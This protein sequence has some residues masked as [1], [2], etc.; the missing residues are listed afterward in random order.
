[1]LA[2]FDLNLP[3]IHRSII[4]TENRASGRTKIRVIS[5]VMHVVF[6]AG[7]WTMYTKGNGSDWLEHQQ[8][9]VTQPAR[10]KKCFNPQEEQKAGLAATTL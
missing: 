4:Y 10:H 3:D 5:K 7:A 6:L 9:N 1:M 8:G 2:G